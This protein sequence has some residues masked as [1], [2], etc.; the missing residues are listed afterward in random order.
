M[1]VKLPHVLEWLAFR[2][3]YPDVP[4][5]CCLRMHG[6]AMVNFHNASDRLACTS[7]AAFTMHARQQRNGDDVS[8]L[9]LVGP[10]TAFRWQ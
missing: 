7:S 5:T 9:L 10:H 2:L 6:N 3:A 4:E 8:C 1:H